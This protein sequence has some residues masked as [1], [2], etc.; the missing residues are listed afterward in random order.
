MAGNTD[1]SMLDFQVLL[2]ESDHRKRL[3][4]FG[5]MIARERDRL[6]ALEQT[7][8]KSSSISSSQSQLSMTDPPRVEP[9]HLNKGAWFRDDCW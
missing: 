2:Q 4:Y 8:R 7:K 9:P 5:K 6:E 3:A 1:G